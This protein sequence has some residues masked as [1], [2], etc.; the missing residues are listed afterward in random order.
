ME[1]FTTIGLSFGFTS[2]IITIATSATPVTY[3]VATVML[4]ILGRQSL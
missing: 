1:A 3:I 2:S 4:R